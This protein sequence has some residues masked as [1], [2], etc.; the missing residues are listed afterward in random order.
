MRARVL[1]GL[2]IAIIAGS[3]VCALAAQKPAKAT[4]TPRL[5]VFSPTA[6]AVEPNIEVVLQLTDEQK[7]K[8]A[9]A[10]QETVQAPAIVELK[11]K[12]GEKADKAKQGKLKEEMTKAQAEL[13][14]RVADILTTEQ[15]ATIQK[16]DDT[17]KQALDTALTKEQKE[18][19]ETT[20][21]KPKKGQ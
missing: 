5:N 7:Q 14:K 11:P 15:K 1:F 6:Y 10:V 12:K 9:K 20:K 16:V 13:K 18:K 17:L 19:L 2:A 3:A 8:V 4:A 21:K